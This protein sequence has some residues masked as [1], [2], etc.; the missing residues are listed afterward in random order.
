MTSPVPRRLYEE[1]LRRN[2]PIYLQWD[3]RTKTLSVP[4]IIADAAFSLLLVASLSGDRPSGDT[5]I[6]GSLLATSLAITSALLVVRLRGK[7]GFQRVWIEEH[8]PPLGTGSDS[9]LGHETP[10]ATSSSRVKSSADYFQ[11]LS[12]RLSK[13]GFAVRREEKADPYLFEIVAVM[14]ANRVGGFRD[15][16]IATS[17]ELPTLDNVEEFHS[18]GMKYALHN[19]SQL[20]LGSGDN[21][22]L[23]SVI[24]SN[25]F[26]D[27]VKR[28]ISA[29]APRG[30]SMHG[31]VG[32]A[33]LA[34]T[35]EQQIYYYTKTPIHGGL[36]Y[37]ALRNF[38]D[39]YFS[40]QTGVLA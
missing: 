27:D 21:L 11:R 15:L 12:L 13:A 5:S 3:N 30:S 22:N 24:V 40:F 31:R 17:L 14:P 37:E 29:T 8:A 35:A 36:R 32:L 7:R 38:A 20:G 9:S 39:T 10:L 23:Y 6:F 33:V 1:H 25:K 2:H 19:K 28:S 26:S 18:L 16:V 34:A 4:V